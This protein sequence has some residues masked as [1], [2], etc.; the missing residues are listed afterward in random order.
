M[1]THS[2][3]RKWEN[4]SQSLSKKE[5]LTGSGEVNVDPIIDAGAND[6][7]VSYSVRMA[8]VKMVY[9]LATTAMTIVP[10]D[11]ADTPLD[12]IDLEANIPFEWT[13]SSA[14]DNPF[15]DDVAYLEV[16]NLDGDA[17]GTLSIR[18]L[19]DATP[20]TTS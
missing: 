20:T 14:E 13:A 3:T 17:D 4:G 1:F 19:V 11:A 10:H 8:Q 16:S 6:L 5:T 7:L 9:F 2:I 15:S 18:T 12:Q